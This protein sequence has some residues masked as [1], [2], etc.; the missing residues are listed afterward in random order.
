MEDNLILQDNNYISAKRAS[1]LFDYS[2]D[3]VGQ[4][5]RAG[6]LESKMIGRSWFV[7]E[8]SIIE[9]KLTAQRMGISS[10]T[11]VANSSSSIVK[12]TFVTALCLVSL[13]FLVQSI[14]HNTQAFKRI[15]Q[16]R[17]VASTVN[18]L[19]SKFNAIAVVPSSNSSD[20]DEEIKQE[21]RDSFSDEVIVKPDATGNSGVI[22]P[23]F[24]K[25]K[26]DDFLYVLVPINSS[27]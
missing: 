10:G 19:V 25:S 7:T 9:H 2:A 24:K 14:S 13:F 20:V 18:T 26:G 1:E 8:R 11:P 22:T 15:S 17:F 12:T 5:C 27:K 21:I 4:L 23:V 6:K 16:G 3:Y